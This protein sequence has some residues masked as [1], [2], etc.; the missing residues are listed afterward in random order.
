MPRKNIYFKDKIDREIEGILEIERQKGANASEANYSQ[1]V[2]ELV[3]LGLMVFKNKEEGPSF[4]LEGFRRDLISKV[5]GSRE[6]MIILTTLVSEMY[7]RMQGPDALANLEEIVSQ[8]I[9]SINRAE[10]AAE[11][12]HFVTDEE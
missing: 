8:N 2:N 4:D 11:M 7:L 6:G 3:R 5:A 1:T 12:Q 10:H 9:D